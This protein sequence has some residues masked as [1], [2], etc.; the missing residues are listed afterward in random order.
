MK[1]HIERSRA[2]FCKGDNV[3]LARGAYEGAP[4][5]F[6]R[7]SADVRWVDITEHDG[8]VRSHPL[9]WLAHAPVATQTAPNL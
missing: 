1:T 9:E 8:T 5:V 7:L 4:G 2:V 6:L 3:A